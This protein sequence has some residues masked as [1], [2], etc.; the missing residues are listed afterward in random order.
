MDMLQVATKNDFWIH[1]CLSFIWTWVCSFWNLCFIDRVCSLDSYTM[2]HLF[3]KWAHVHE[4]LC[5]FG[6][7]FAKT[8][9][10]NPQ[11]ANFVRIVL[12]YT[13]WLIRPIFQVSKYCC[14]VISRINMRKSV[15]SISK[16]DQNTRTK[17][18]HVYPMKSN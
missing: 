16:K 5:C 13:W 14:L 12:S 1:I 2:F 15:D 8:I 10:P 3:T 18:Y 11:L 6:I 7:I 4:D 17:V 9:L